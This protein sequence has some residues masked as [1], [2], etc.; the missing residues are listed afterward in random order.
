MK[1]MSSI[2]AKSHIEHNLILKNALQKTISDF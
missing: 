1:K 2:P